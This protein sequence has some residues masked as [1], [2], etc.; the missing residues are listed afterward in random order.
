MFKD[1]PG[2]G[3][4]AKIPCCQC[5]V[6]EFNPWSGNYIPRAT[7]ESLHAATKDLPTTVKIK[8][9]ECS[10]YDLVQPNE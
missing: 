6:P 7:T 8:E 5:R 9:P 2:F 3:P 1:F 4:V 10:S